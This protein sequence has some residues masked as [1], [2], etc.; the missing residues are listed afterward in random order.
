M[1]RN[2]HSQGEAQVVLEQSVWKERAKHPAE[3]RT[4]L[5]LS[6]GTCTGALK[7]QLVAD[8]EFGIETTALRTDWR[9]DET[10][11]QPRH[12]GD[13]D[14]TREAACAAS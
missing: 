4:C 9:E 1:K 12:S 14:A 3:T 13:Q 5:R 11:S 7:R 10:S 2:Q 6:Y 8:E